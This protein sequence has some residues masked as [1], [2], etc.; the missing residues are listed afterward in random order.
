MLPHTPPLHLFQA[1]GIELEYMIVDERTLDVR[2]IAD[3]L[4]AHVCANVE[5]G[6][7]EV[8]R[9]ISWSN[10]LTRHLVEFKTTEPAPPA[11]FA[12]LSA[13][14]DANIARATA[15]L[16]PLGCRL[17]PGAM[18]PWMNPSTEMHLWP[19]G[20]QDVY[21]AFDR[22]FDCHGH[23][24]ANLQSTHI[25]L[26]FEGDEEFARLHAAIRL[27]LP[28]LPALA[29][30]SPIIDG[31]ATGTLDNRLA[32]YKSN[33]RRVPSVSGKVIP[34][35]VF[36]HADYQS[37]IL[38][39]IYADLA[40]LD[41]DGLLRHEWAN[42]RGA[43]ARFERNAIE[44]RVLDV[45]E[46]PAADIALCAGITAVLRWLVAESPATLPQQQAWQVDP[47]AKLL[48]GVIRH[49]DQSSIENTGYLETLGLRGIKRASPTE[50][51]KHL[52]HRAGVLKN[53]TP[54][55]PHFHPLKTILDRGP[56]A[57]RILAALGPSAGDRATQ[58][59]VYRELCDCLEQGRVFRAS[60]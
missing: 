10:E 8:D 7:A 44:I 41:P 15:L 53:N 1:V 25:N 39:R 43:I 29:A 49:A 28:I 47:L 11:D 6:E 48:D 3:Q 9:G 37:R 30:S 5:D 24:W 34:E 58:L 13:R 14:F 51:W 31:H 42:A 23:G 17:M 38:D 36:T 33:A 19:H 54:A 21:A 59:E 50:L 26:P 57:R 40:P 16:R 45:Q 18:H 27:L 52:F 4:L 35:P 2:P 32:V 60:T 22:I 56:L 12:D 20:Y 55:E 46:C